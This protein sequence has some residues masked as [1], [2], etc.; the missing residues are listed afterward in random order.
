MTLPMTMRSLSFS[1]PTFALVAAVGA[2]LAAGVFFA[3]STFVMGGIG[4]LPDP[5]GLAAMQQINRA[6]PTPAFMT[7]WLGTALLCL[8]MGIDQLQHGGRAVGHRDAHRVS[9]RAL[10]VRVAELELPAVDAV[11]DELGDEPEP[12]AV[13]QT[14]VGHR[15][16]FA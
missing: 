1:S 7:L 16:A 13:R 9:G 10:G 8:A 3:F 5:E 15:Y 6:A 11:L 4:R 14:G 12:I 2:G